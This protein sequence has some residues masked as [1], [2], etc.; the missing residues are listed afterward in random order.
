MNY[1]DQKKYDRAKKKIKD[2]KGFYSHLTVYLIV[3]IGITLLRL[4]VFE[5]RWEFEAPVWTYLLTPFF[6][7]I[8]LAFHGLFVFQHKFSFFR[9]WEKKKIQQYMDREDEIRDQRWS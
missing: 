8:G 6:W 5:G 9:N 7:G 4:N 1:Q 2:I 3:N